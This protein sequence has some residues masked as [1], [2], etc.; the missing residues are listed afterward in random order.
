MLYII[1]PLVQY[2]YIV[3][4][5]HW[6]RH[7]A[8]ACSLSTSPIR[9]NLFQSTFKMSGSGGYYKYRCKYWLTYNC[10]NWV[11]VNNAPCAYCLVSFYLTLIYVLEVTPIRQM[12]GMSRDEPVANKH[13]I[14]IK[15][16]F[17]KMGVGEASHR[18]HKPVGRVTK[19]F[20]IKLVATLSRYPHFLKH[21]SYAIS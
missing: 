3:H 14:I 6:Q 8:S 17:R 13:I 7:L 10:P 21:R 4:P 9:L 11:W 12:V 19:M 16:S 18:L 5:I 2:I 15:N 20:S 1:F